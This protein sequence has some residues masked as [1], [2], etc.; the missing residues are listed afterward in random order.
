MDYY[1]ALLDVDEQIGRVRTII[2]A[3][4]YADSTL[5]WL[6]SDNGP[7][8]NVADGFFPHPG[9]CVAV[10]GKD[11][12]CGGPGEAR[13]LRG[14]KRDYWEGG[15]RIPGIISYPPLVKANFVSEHTMTT[16]DV[17]PTTMALLKVE[18][19]EN[20]SSWQV[21]GRSVLPA[22]A[23]TSAGV[24]NEYGRG[25]LFWRQPSALG[26]AFR[27]GDWKFVNQSHSCVNA[28][29]DAALYNLRTD[30]GETKNL[31]AEQPEIFAAMAKNMSD[32]KWRVI[33]SAL[34]ESRCEVPFPPG[35]TPPH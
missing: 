25:W 32:W 11:G 17:L 14:R 10:G 16:E 1:G 21:D 6:G 30:I 33:E 26:G 9:P 8:V 5:L 7:E 18:R 34:K 20:Q 28:S 13:P 12:G 22:L 31:R 19:F 3:E 24:F 27:H 29:C 15:H 23:G 2:K 35:P 4:G